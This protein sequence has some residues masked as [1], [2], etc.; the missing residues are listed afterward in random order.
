[1][2]VLSINIG[3]RLMQF[4]TPKIMGIVNVTPDSFFEGSRTMLANDIKRRIERMRFE[5]ADIIDIGGYSSR[6]GASDVSTEEEYRRLSL[7]LKCIREV[8]PEAVIS[9]DT[10]RAEVADRC[11]KEYGV[12]IIN[13]ISGGSL[14]PLMWKTVAKLK[15]AYVLM[16]SRGTPADM[17]TLTAYSDVTSEVIADLAFKAATLRDMGV[18][19]IIIDPGFG[20][21]K[22]I[23]Q[24]FQLL[25]SLKEF[26]KTGMPLLVG[27][28]RKSMIWR[29]LGITPTESL[30]GTVAL[31]TVALHGGADILRV[32]DVAPAVRTVKLLEHLT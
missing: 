24:N 13:D 8:W 21:A 15:V 22:D 1:M 14:D 29:T 2:K 16:H 25:S 19:D 9:V 26:K 7:G 10:F 3:G 31:N 17:E 5:G 32:H 20:F 4:T 27:I 6:P 18:A 23:K 12:A 11:V 30:A 28:S